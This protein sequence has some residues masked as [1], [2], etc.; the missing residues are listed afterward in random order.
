MFRC[1]LLMYVLCWPHLCRRP[2][3]TWQVGVWNTEMQAFMVV[4]VC[5]FGGKV[6]GR[7]LFFTFGWGVYGIQF[8]LSSVPKEECWKI[9]RD[10]EKGFWRPGEQDYLNYT[11]VVQATSLSRKQ[12]RGEVT[13]Q[14]LHTWEMHN[15]RW[16]KCVFRSSGYKLK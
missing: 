16:E 10:S 15:R 4:F 14:L 13:L 12:E 2:A 1:A 6:V 7:G 5:L 9:K 8:Y 3:F 11:A